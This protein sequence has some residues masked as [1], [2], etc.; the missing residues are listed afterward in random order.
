MMG[1]LDG[2]II[3]RTRVLPKGLRHSLR[4]STAFLTPTWPHE[5][6]SKPSRQGRSRHITRSNRNA[7]I[8]HTARNL[9]RPRT[10]RTLIRATQKPAHWPNDPTNK[11]PLTHL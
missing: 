1:L 11:C 10:N 8:E 6:T 2:F 9:C 5:P 3:Y 4:H 7:H